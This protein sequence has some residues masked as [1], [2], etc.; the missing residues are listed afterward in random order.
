VSADD[1]ET[2]EYKYEPEMNQAEYY[3]GHF[4]KAKILKIFRNG[5]KNLLNGQIS[6]AVHMTI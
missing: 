2:P 1:H 3:I 6:K 4:N 5:M